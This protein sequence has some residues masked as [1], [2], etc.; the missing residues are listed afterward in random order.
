MTVQRKPGKSRT[1]PRRVER[2][3]RPAAIQPTGILFIVDPRKFAVTHVSANVGAML[4]LSPEKLFGTDIRALFDAE[5]A[6][7][8]TLYAAA[9]AAAPGP[10]GRVDLAAIGRGDKWRA[11]SHR[12][13]RGLIVEVA[14]LP[15]RALELEPFLIAAA[16][17]LRGAG[18]RS[19]IAATTAAIARRL[20]EMTGYDR[21]AVVRCQAQGAEVLAEAG[22]SATASLAG[23]DRSAALCALIRPDTAEIPVRMVRDAGAA[24]VPVLAAPGRLRVTQPDLRG[25]ILNEPSAAQRQALAELG[26]KAALVVALTN[27]DRPWGALAFLHASPRRMSLPFR[28]ALQVM[29]DAIAVRFSVA[30]AVDRESEILRRRRAL[31]A[32]RRSLERER[33]DDVPGIL[34][35]RGAA[36]LEVADA[37]GAWFDLPQGDVGL[38]TVP[39]MAAV[40]ETMKWCR[41]RSTTAV[42]AVDRLSSPDPLP[43][44]AAMRAVLFARLPRS[45]GAVLLFGGPAKPSS[46]SARSAPARWSEAGIEIAAELA[47]TVDELLSRIADRRTLKRA[48]ANE[49]KLQAILDATQDGLVV[50]DRDGIVLEFSA[51]AERMFG[52]PAAD[53]KGRSIEMLVPEGARASHRAGLARA[54]ERPGPRSFGGDGSLRALRRD[55]STFPFEAALTPLVLGGR[56]QFIIAVRDIGD[57]LAGEQR[58]RFWFEH[59]SVGYSVSNLAGRRLRVNPAL[60]SILGYSEQDLLA[61]DLHATYHAEDAVQSRAWRE[62]VAAGSD[63]PYRAVQRFW[64]QDGKMVWGRVT[65]SPIRRPG[66][67]E[68]LILSELVD[69]T[70]LMEADAKRR[71]ALLR[72]ESANAAKS[73][74]LA[75]MSHELRTPLNAIIGLSDMMTAE[76]MGPIGN[77]RY[78]E[79]IHDISKAGR[80]LLDLVTDVLDASRIEAGGYRLAVAPLHLGEVMDEMHRLMLPLASERDVALKRDVPAGLPILH[81]DRRALKQV[82]INV[83]SNAIK[84]TPGKGRVSVRAAVDEA[85]AIEIEVADTGPGIS[86]EDLRHVVEPFYRTADAYTTSAAS[87]AGLGLA[88]ANGLVEAHGGVFRIASEVGRGTTVTLRFPPAPAAA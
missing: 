23:P 6:A 15:A 9:K 3:G 66:T 39:D 59:S 75:T 18:A 29:A 33:A 69:I 44:G 78:G 70:D 72:A 52:W 77:A 31:A 19:G 48:M 68:T 27:G 46:V 85:G 11:A 53:V 79:Y 26:A 22:K 13:S 24:P 73:Q 5:F 47:H 88:I 50:V 41:G 80:H 2:G 16:A 60:C 58:D 25:A 38:G 82:L 43:G 61:R 4:G 37:A 42:F 67:A 81:A 64:R 49:A 7:A 55:G 57:R 28:T 83:V 63:V 71:A 54:L 40:R 34:R 12:A 76:I 86:A 45:H 1:S 84:F 21:V 30:E 14:P 35:R 17:A 65:A 87:G 62:T 32:L 51:N 74:F 8:L 20:R 36:L 56:T 10:A